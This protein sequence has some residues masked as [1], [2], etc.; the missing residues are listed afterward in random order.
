MTQRHKV[1]VSYHHGNDQR[2]RDDFERRF[3]S[4]N[5]HIMESRSV[6]PGAINPN[7]RTEAAIQSIRDNYISD[8]TVIVVLIGINTWRR[9]FVDWEIY[10]GLRDTA[11]NQRCGLLGIL[12]PTYPINRL[13]CCNTRTSPPYEPHTI[14]PRLYDNLGNGFAKIYDWTESPRSMQSWI[15]TAFQRRNQQPNP[16]LSRDLFANNR[17][18]KL[19]RWYD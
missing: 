10:Y 9:K 17:K 12:L 2:Y 7:N 18:R 13:G 11:H 8:A 19:D 4:N 15:H 16:D 5:Y 6:Q 3:S 14:P 1:F